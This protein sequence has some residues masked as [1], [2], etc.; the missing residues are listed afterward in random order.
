MKET[1]EFLYRQLLV[2]PLAPRALRAD[3]Q[4]SLRID[5]RRQMGEKSHFLILAER[6]R[7]CEIEHQLDARFEFVH[8]LTT[9]PTAPGRTKPQLRE[10]D[11]DRR[12]DMK[13]RSHEA[14][15]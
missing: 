8:I 14:N 9:G 6:G 2:L 5:S 3:V 1:D 13:Y 7:V 15:F 12:C 11:L 10:R 4:N